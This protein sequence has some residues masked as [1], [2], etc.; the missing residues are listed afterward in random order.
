MKSLVIVA[1]ILGTVNLSFSQDKM[2]KES[3]DENIKIEN[4]PTVVI[5]SAEKDFSIYLPDNNPDK[6]VRKLQ[7]RFIAYDLGKDYEGFERYLV[8]M[9]IDEGTLTAKYNEH[10]KLIN[11]VEKYKNINLPDKVIY[12]IYKN[13]PEWTVVD[14]KYLYSQKEG[15]I[16]KKQYDLKIK[17]GNLTKKI[18][19]KPDGEIISKK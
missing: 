19:L 11:V 12:S 13:Y 2:K 6:D 3:E 16:L 7:E 15:D 1:L 4:L 14:D 8:I 18:T 10:G 5:K 9:Y 17:K